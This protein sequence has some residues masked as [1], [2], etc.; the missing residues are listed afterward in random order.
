MKV[1]QFELEGIK[2]SN[3][4]RINSYD[5]ILEHRTYRVNT[6]KY[7]AANPCFLKTFILENHEHPCIV[8]RASLSK[9][10]LVLRM[11]IDVQ[12]PF[13]VGF[14]KDKK[15]NVIRHHPNTY[16]QLV[17]DDELQLILNRYIY[18]AWLPLFNVHYLLFP[19][20]PR[21]LT[22][23]TVDRV[24]KILRGD[25]D[26]TN[27]IHSTVPK[28][29]TDAGFYFEFTPVLSE[30]FIEG[31]ITNLDRKVTY[32]HG[33]GMVTYSDESV[34]STVENVRRQEPGKEYLGHFSRLQRF[35]ATV[36]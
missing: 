9:E 18:D 24:L 27:A 13:S 22:T 35:W 34:R 20:N 6:F 16:N 2:N 19:N 12:P 23:Q 36:S 7:T 31:E 1:P 30:F 8:A 3:A 14:T 32:Y 4:E 5:Q 26:N 11:L 28:I 17:F 21:L 25:K 15:E 10:D 33:D 29:M